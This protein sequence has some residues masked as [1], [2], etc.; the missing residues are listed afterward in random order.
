MALI[1][2]IDDEPKVRQM[3]QRILALAGHSVIEAD[4]G[5]AALRQLR[6]NTPAVVLTDIL[7]PGTEGI[8]TIFEIR[9]A[10]PDTKIIAMSGGGRAGNFDFLKMAERAGADAVLAKPFRAA[11]LVA[12]VERL[13]SPA[14]AGVA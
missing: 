2:V 8:E 9:R 13:L 7:M 14:R 6:D 10:A 1:L 11:E 12:M 5:A 3:I 4:E